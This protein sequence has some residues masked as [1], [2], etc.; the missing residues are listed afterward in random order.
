VAFVG[1]FVEK[2]G[3]DDLLAALAALGPGRPS[4]VF[5]GAGP[6]LASMQAY[7]RELR[8]D[9]TF[10]GTQTPAEVREALLSSRLLA[11]PSRIA[12]DGDTEGLPTTIMEAAALG[13]PVVATHHSGIPEAVADGETG[14]L[15]PEADRTALAANLAR[16]LADEDL[17]AR[18]GRQARALMVSRFDL[19]AQTARLEEIYDEVAAAQ[20]APS[21]D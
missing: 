3:A 11:A 20:Y 10:L 4:A 15:C 17:R 1:R 9:A 8:V 14:L 19:A 18:L 13:L 16:L 5:I 7:A 6:L 2:K 21:H 12:R